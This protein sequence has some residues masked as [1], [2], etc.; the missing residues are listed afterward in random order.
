MLEILHS[1]SNVVFQPGFD[2]P[3]YS[4]INPYALGFAMMQDIKRICTAPTDEDREWFP[5]I[6]GT[7]DWRAVL[8]DAWANY[9]DESFIRQFLSPHLIRKMK[10]FRMTD[11][12][13]DSH[14]TI[15]DI[16]DERG[17]KRVRDALAD[18]YDVP[19]NE[20][21]IQIVDVDL[22]G[23]RELVLRQNI[24]NGIPLAEQG[25]EEVLPYIRRL[26]GYDVRLEGVDQTTGETVYESRV[27]RPAEAAT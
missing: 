17:Y 18:S 25:R 23:D 7:G 2:D 22:R 11:R 13:Q 24:R 14:V 4:G 1:H 26:W 15:S 6:A 3:R 5:L 12:S 8:R 10:L 20:P 27:S 19:A 21:D 16:H 9:R